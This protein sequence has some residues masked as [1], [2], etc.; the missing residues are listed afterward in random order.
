MLVRYLQDL[1]TWAMALSVCAV[2][3]IATM[4]AQG[5]LHR[6]WRFDSRTKLNE[7]AGF[8]IAVVGVVYAVLLASIAILVLERH[9][10]ADVAVEAEAG[11]V[12]NLFGTSVGL[13]PEIALHMRSV[14]TDYAN[15]VIEDEWPEMTSGVPPESGWQD[16]G[17]EKVSALRELLLGSN[18][19]EEVHTIAVERSL[20][21]ID[22]LADA[23]RD[24]IFTT[25]SGLAGLVWAVVTAGGAI[26]VGLGLFFGLPSWRGHLLMVDMLSLSI[27]LVFVLIIAMDRPFVGESGVTAKPFLRVM[28]EIEGFGER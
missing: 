2:A 9:Q 14:I 1:P 28:A 10:R 19:T 26:T 18:P 5:I 16:K 4:I 12:S 22:E 21:Q 8:L 3:V 27:A 13:P 23:R 6:L 24:R 20:E 17:W 7:V 25:G 15:T 11:E